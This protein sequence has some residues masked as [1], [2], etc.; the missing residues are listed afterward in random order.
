[1]LRAAH[2]DGGRLILSLGNGL[3]AIVDSGGPLGEFCEREGLSAAVVNRVE[4]IFEEVVANIVRHGFAPGSGQS[5]SVEVAMAG[6]D[7]VLIFVDDG[8]AFNPT[9]RA[10]PAPSTQ[11]ADAPIGGLGIVLVRR[12]AR[13]VEYARLG[14]SVG[15][16]QAVNRLTVQ[17]AAGSRLPAGQ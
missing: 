7:I 14:A 17:V 13:T 15:E 6:D 4:V 9:Q 10:A 5:I 8:S 2:F 16:F 1:M 3:G 11:L 12:L